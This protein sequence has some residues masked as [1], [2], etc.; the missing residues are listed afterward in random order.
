M[1]SD[2][3]SSDEVA[4]SRIRIR[5]LGQDGARNRQPL[6]LPARQL[7]PALAHDRV[8]ALRETLRKLIDAGD[9]AGIQEFLFPRLRMREHHIL[10]D[11]AIEEKRFLQHHAQLRAIAVQPHGR[12]IDAIHQHPSRVRL[13]KRAHQADD[14]RFP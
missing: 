6:P 1:A 3:E 10:F 12:Q 7:H 14:R 5:G 8:V 11:G 13:V 2:S 4:S 9:A